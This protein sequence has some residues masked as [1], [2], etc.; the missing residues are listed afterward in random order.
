MFLGDICLRIYRKN[1]R[2]KRGMDVKRVLSVLLVCTL[3]L[4]SF[5]ACGN[6]SGTVTIDKTEL[7][8]Q[9]GDSHTFTVMESDKELSLDLFTWKSTDESVAMVVNGKVVALKDGEAVIV[10]TKDNHILSCSVKIGN[11][12]Q[13]TSLKASTTKRTTTAA[14]KPKTTAKSTTTTTTTTTTKATTTTTKSTACTHQ[15]ATQTKYKCTL[16][17][18]VDESLTYAY[19]TEWIVQNGIYED[20]SWT[21]THNVYSGKYRYEY[22]IDYDAQTS[23]TMCKVSQT[24]SEN[25]GMLFVAFSFNSAGK[26]ED[27][28]YHYGDYIERDTLIWLIGLW[29]IARYTDVTTLTYYDYGSDYGRTVDSSDLNGARSALNLI[30][31]TMADLL[32]GRVGNT[33]YSG[34]TLADLGFISFE[35]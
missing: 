2:L 14:K 10:A 34:L 17:G 32:D 31:Y 15:Y 27:Y 29:D 11:G 35:A 1:L 23:E 33:N 7:E 24:S 21:I 18:K 20:N 30:L 9:V 4:V 13:T 16:C 28:Y 25:T 26:V 3:I 12:N 6:D 5:S 19:F 22:E 8:M